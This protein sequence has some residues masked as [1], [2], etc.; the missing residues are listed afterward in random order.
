MR[1]GPARGLGPPPLPPSA[2]SPP[3]AGGPPQLP[4]GTGLWMAERL[5]RFGGG[6]GSGAPAPPPRPVPRREARPVVAA[7]RE[8]RSA[9]V[10]G[11]GLGL[12]A[13]APTGLRPSPPSDV[14][15]GEEGEGR[16]V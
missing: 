3:P 15:D 7:P 16:R 4:P 9:V 6:G 2:P 5:S 1:P 14:V 10:T 12:S 13:A 11:P 8:A